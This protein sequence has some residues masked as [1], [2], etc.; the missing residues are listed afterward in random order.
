MHGGNAPQVKAKAEQRVREEKVR[1]AVVTL[2]L[3]ADVTPQAAL[4]EE[5]C[6]SVGAVRWLESRIR[7]LDPDLLIF[8]VQSVIRGRQA[9][10]NV[11]YEEHRAVPHALWVIYRSERDHLV[12]VCRAAVTAGIAERQI[13]VAEQIGGVLAD[14]IHA[15]LD[16]I[17]LSAEQRMTA[18][19]SVQRHLRSLAAIEQGKEIA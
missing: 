3:P 4:L 1:Q 2:G 17:G 18:V 14:T 13:A 5:V 11:D 19:T 9:I 15:V 7:E 10:G 6:R 16:D 12:S 8:S